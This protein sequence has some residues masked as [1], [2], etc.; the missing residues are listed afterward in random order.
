[1]AR[2]IP[3]RRW[4]ISTTAAASPA[5]ATEKREATLRARSTNRAAAAESMPAPTLQRGQQPQLL[6]G[7]PE[8]FA[9]GRYKLHGR[10]VRQDRLD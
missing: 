9:A 2:G 6:V 5:V 4:Q 8:S 3:S 7:D 1:M 10:R